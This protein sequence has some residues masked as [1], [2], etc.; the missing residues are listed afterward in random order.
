MS[1]VENVAR[2]GGAIAASDGGLV[3][4]G[5]TFTSNTAMVQGGAVYRTTH[6]ALTKDGGLDWFSSCT[7]EGNHASAN[8]GGLYVN[9]GFSLSVNSSVFLG[10]SAGKEEG[11]IS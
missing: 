10:N 9:G 4:D 11:P 6:G 7:F 5:T 2:E 8:G 1:F 3:L